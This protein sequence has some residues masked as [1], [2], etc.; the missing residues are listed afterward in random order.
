MAHTTLE[1]PDTYDQRHMHMVDCIQ[2][3]QSSANL[4][5]TAQWPMAPAGPRS[6]ETASVRSA[7][8]MQYPQAMSLM[9]SRSIP[10]SIRHNSLNMK[11][12]NGLLA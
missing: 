4:K 1:V 8:Y 2:T 10:R 7:K 5:A 6:A 12:R 9:V 11:V 3:A